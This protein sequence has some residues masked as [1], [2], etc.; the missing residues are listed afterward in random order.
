MPTFLSPS[1]SAM[2]ICTAANPK[3]VQE[4]LAFVMAGAQS[5][6]GALQQRTYARLHQ[7][8][9][10]HFDGAANRKSCERIDW[11]VIQRLFEFVFAHGTTEWRQIGE[12]LYAEMQYV[13]DP[14][15]VL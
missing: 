1:Q 4:I 12:E 3:V 7:L 5:T 9:Q 10:N 13:D 11:R 2:K 15:P 8:I 14:P 6:D